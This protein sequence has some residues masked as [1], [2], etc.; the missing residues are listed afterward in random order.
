MLLFLPRILCNRVLNEQC[1]W[2]CDTT[3]GLKLLVSREFLVCT[4]ETTN[5]ADCPDCIREPFARRVLL[6]SI[7]I[8]AL[9]D[10]DSRTS[11]VHCATLF[12]PSAHGLS[13]VL[14]S[15]TI[16]CANRTNG[17]TLFDTP[18]FTVYLRLW[19]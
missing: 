12:H 14:D 4:L 19:I 6:R 13:V 11:R 1:R 15:L 8:L 3:D 9:R 17:G 7:I 5:H 18:K 16:L 2:Q 10:Q